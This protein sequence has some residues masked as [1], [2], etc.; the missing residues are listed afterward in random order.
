MELKVDHLTILPL[1][2]SPDVVIGIEDEENS[3]T[4]TVDTK[5]METP[6]LAKS[7]SEGIVLVSADMFDEPK[8]TKTSPEE[9]AKSLIEDIVSKLGPEGTHDKKD[10]YFHYAYFNL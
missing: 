7:D 4:T 3:A 9:F 10:E 6:A 2:M 1:Q 8:E 5:Q